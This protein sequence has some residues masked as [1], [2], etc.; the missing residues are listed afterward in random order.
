[1]ASTALRACP[2]RDP[3]E[4]SLVVAAR[5]RVVVALIDAAATG[6]DF[7][8]GRAIVDAELAERAA[9]GVAELADEAIRHH[10]SVAVTLVLDRAE[11]IVTD[12]LRPRFEAVLAEAKKTAA[13]IAGHGMSAEELLHAPKRLQE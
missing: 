3:S 8:D 6:G 10:R 7:P 5:E 13:A 11:S 12:H 1:M 2:H 9:A 4:V